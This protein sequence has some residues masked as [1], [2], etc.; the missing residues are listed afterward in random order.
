MDIPEHKDLETLTRLADKYVKV[1]T[2]LDRQ[3]RRTRAAPVRLVEA[4]SGQ[5]E[6]DGLCID[7]AE[8]EEE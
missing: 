7:G 2:S 8:V 4:Y 3:R 1:M 5:G 6:E